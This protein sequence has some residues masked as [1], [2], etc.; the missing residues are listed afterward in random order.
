MNADHTESIA[1]A[2]YMQE[3]EKH[4]NSASRF[5]LAV[6]DKFTSYQVANIIRKRYSECLTLP[7]FV[8][9]WALVVYQLGEFTIGIA[10]SGSSPCCLNGADKL[11]D[12]SL[13]SYCLN[14]SAKSACPFSFAT[15]N[16]VFPLST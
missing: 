8:Y 7:P 14:N 16:A 13:A 15:S 9:V 6:I 11:K 5:P 2:N 12:H 10:V 4:H 3:A 1:P